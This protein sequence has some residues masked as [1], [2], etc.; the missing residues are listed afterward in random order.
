MN[1]LAVSGFRSRLKWIHKDVNKIKKQFRL[2]KRD[3]DSVDKKDLLEMIDSVEKDVKEI[4]KDMNEQRAR[5]K[6]SDWY[7]SLGKPLSS[8]Q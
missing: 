4:E 2:A 8:S 1:H 6:S 5:E 3:P 7:Y